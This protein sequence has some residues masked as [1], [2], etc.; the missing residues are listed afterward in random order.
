MTAWSAI[1]FLLRTANR[2]WNRDHRWRRPLA[3]A[4]FPAY[5]V[6]HVAIVLIGWWIAPLLL[7]HI[8]EFMILLTGTIAACLSAVAAGRA[9]PALGWLIG[10]HGV[11]PHAPSARGSAQSATG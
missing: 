11:A 9:W 1:L 8:T 3:D 2:F 4:V 7:P 6:H 5:I 10:M